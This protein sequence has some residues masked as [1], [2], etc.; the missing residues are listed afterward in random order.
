MTSTSE[1]PVTLMVTE[2]APQVHVLGSLRFNWYVVAESGSY[3]VVDAGLPAHWPQIG[4]LL[5]A[6]GAGLDDVEAVLITYGHG[7]HAGNAERL[8][9]GAAATVYVHPEDREEL[10]SGKMPNPSLAGLVLLPRRP[11][12]LSFMAEAIRGGVVPRFP[13]VRQ[14]SEFADG[15]VLDVPGRPRVVHV[16]GHTPGSCALHLADAGTVF[17]G[18]ALVT[19]NPFAPRWRRNGPQLCIDAAQDDPAQAHAS[20]D[21]LAGLGARTALPGHGEP[22]HGGID[23]AVD[24]ARRLGR[25]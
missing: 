6:L 23:A 14:L 3:T 24:H 9:T 13:A 1:R 17:T 8:R 2:V 16:P 19:H 25:V 20:L 11:A 12:M 15:E 21:R 10:R 7:D 5:T 18:D 22:W 4:T